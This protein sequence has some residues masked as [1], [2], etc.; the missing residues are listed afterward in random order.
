MNKRR[1]KLPSRRPTSI[2]SSI[3]DSIKSLFS[4]RNEELR[5]MKQVYDRRTRRQMKLKV[6]QKE[7]AKRAQL[8]S[9]N[10]DVSSIANMGFIR[11]QT[12]MDDTT[13]LDELRRE[14]DDLKSKL[15]QRNKDLKFTQTKNE[16]LQK[17]LDEAKIDRS[18]VKSRRDIRNLEKENLKPHIELP[19]SPQ[20]KVNP[21]VTSS[22][23]RRSSFDHLENEIAPPPKLNFSAK[24]PSLPHAETQ[25][26]D[27]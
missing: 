5:I 7:A 1:G 20:R 19:P 15:R 25:S 6:L 12:T 16:L 9:K 14:I 21:L 3:F 24:Y 23:I 10:D 17:A 26:Q 27:Q 18:Y 13:T 22:P 2:I 11:E 8:N 4:P